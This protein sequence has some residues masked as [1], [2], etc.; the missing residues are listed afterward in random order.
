[1]IARLNGEMNKML[2]EVELRKQFD[3]QGMQ[4]AGGTADDVDRR[5]RG[6]HDRWSKIIREANIKIEG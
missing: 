5:M 6:E 2:L 4:V 1:M 3:A